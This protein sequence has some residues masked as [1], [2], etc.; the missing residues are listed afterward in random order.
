APPSHE[1]EQFLQTTFRS[2]CHLIFQ[3]SREVR[4]EFER[5]F[6]KDVRRQERRSTSSAGPFTSGSAAWF[7]FLLP[8]FLGVFQPPSWTSSASTSSALMSDHDSEQRNDNK[9]QDE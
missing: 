1:D 2:F 5:R 3:S 9:Y 8:I 6:L 7:T 4:I